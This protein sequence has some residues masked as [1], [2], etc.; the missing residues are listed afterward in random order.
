MV[1]QIK[2]LQK[3]IIEFGIGRQLYYI[4]S[5]VL[6]YAYI[7]SAQ[8]LTTFYIII[9]KLYINEKLDFSVWNTI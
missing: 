4:F 8:L 3:Q 5:F 1:H 2:H 6:A 9:K 7:S